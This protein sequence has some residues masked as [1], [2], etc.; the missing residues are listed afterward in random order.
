[1]NAF[2]DFT[3]ILSEFPHQGELPSRCFL[4]DCPCDSTSPPDAIVI[5]VEASTA[6]KARHSAVPVYRCAWSD[7]PCT[8]FI[9]GT[10][11]EILS[12]FRQCHGIVCGASGDLVCRW[13]SCS[14]A[15]GPLKI[16]SV[17]RHIARHLGIQYRCSQCELVMCRDDLVRAHIR[18]SAGCTG[19][20]VQ[21]MAG[22][23]ARQIV[24]AY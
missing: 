21:V 4:C 17:A 18:K 9:E 22:P 19:A 15:E 7:E 23:G 2:P 6:I 24:S 1:M 16:G 10:R 13:G 5:H 11:T 12:H 20:I 8:M 14:M 3:P